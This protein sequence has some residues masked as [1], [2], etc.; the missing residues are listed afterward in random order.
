VCG[1]S[2]EPHSKEIALC[3]YRIAQEALNNALRYA[4]ASAVT[5]TFT[6]VLN[7]YSMTIQDS[8]IGFDLIPNVAFLAG[9]IMLAAPP[10]A[11]MLQ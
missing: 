9:G 7:S 1:A 10:I 5:V 2:D 8:G 3:F 4:Q 11:L 6:K